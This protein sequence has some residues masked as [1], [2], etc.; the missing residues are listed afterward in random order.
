MASLGHHEQGSCLSYIGKLIMRIMQRDKLEAC[1]TSVLRAP[2][3]S[4]ARWWKNDRMRSGL[5]LGIGV[6]DDAIYDPEWQPVCY[7]ILFRRHRFVR[8]NH[9]DFFAGIRRHDK[10]RQSVNSERK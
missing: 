2:V 3:G 5:Y 10:C 1:P 7:G 6:N 8:L 4:V 9:R